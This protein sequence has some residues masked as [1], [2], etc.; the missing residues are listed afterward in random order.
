[1]REGETES[2]IGILRHRMTGQRQ[3]HCLAP[4]FSFSI[5][6]MTVAS[7]FPRGFL[8]GLNEIT[9]I[10]TQSQVQVHSRY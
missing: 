4:N 10:Q 5:I 3:E 2:P 1:M 9:Y 7:F 8:R 6:R